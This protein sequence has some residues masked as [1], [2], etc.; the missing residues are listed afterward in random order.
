VSEKTIGLIG[1]GA[2]G[3]EI[4]RSLVEFGRGVISVLDGRSESS[5]RRAEAA[6]IRPVRD[7]ETLV[8]ESDVVLSVVPPGVASAVAEEVAG[9]AKATG[10]ASTFVDANA[11]SPGRARAIAATL[12]TAGM[13]YVDGGIIGGPPTR[14]R[15]T[16]IYLS[17]VG[18]DDI[19]AALTTPAIRVTWLGPEPAAASAIKM[20]YAAWTKGT[21]AL[22]LAIR[23]LA[24]AEGVEDALVAEWQRSQPAAL[25]W[26]NRAPGTAGK[27]WR[28]VAE[29]EEIAASLDGANVPSGAFAAAAGIYAR[30]EAYKDVREP[31]PLD[32]MID[33]ILGPAGFHGV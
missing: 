16:A 21:N 10:A 7:L 12:A 13:R 26:S 5:R 33:R 30:L 6:H 27:A 31:P 15:P 22:A 24:R 11:I 18:G 29:M 25:D 17:G 1:A 32:E 28:W 9:A 14:E 19:V 3:A 23:S 8:S 4:G 2:M 20:A